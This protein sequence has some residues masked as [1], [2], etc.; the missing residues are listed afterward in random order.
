[1]LLNVLGGGQEPVFID[2]LKDG[3]TILTESIT[4][5]DGRGEHSWD[6]PAELFGTIELCAYRFGVH[7]LPVRKTRVIYIRQANELKIHTE[8]DRQE[9]RPGRTARI[10][11][12]LVDSQG[13]PTPGAISLSAVD[14]AV[15]SVLDQR[16][17]MEQTFFTLEQ[18]LLEPV[19]AIYPWSPST[20]FDVPVEER[21]L[22]EQALFAGTT[23]RTRSDRDVILRELLPFVDNSAEIFQVLERPD[24]EELIPLYYIPDEVLSILRNESGQHTLNVSTFPAKVRETESR[25]QSGIKF[26][27]GLWTSYALISGLLLF[28]YVCTILF[29]KNAVLGCLTLGGLLTVLS[30]LMLPAVQ[31]AREAARRSTAKNNLKQIELA[32][33]N[34]MDSE[35]RL[36]GVGDTA[37]SQASNVRVRQWFPET[38]LWRPELIT[39]DDGRV[40]LDVDLADSITTWRLA[41]SAVSASGQLGA[42]QSAIRVFQPFF[43]DLNL[44]VALTRGDEVSVPI[45]I[46]NYLDEPQHVEL[47]LSEGSWFESLDEVE[48]SIELKAGE[49][50]S[51]SYRL[52]VNKVGRHE[53]QV[54][55]V[56]GDVADAIRRRIEVVPDGR[57]IERVVNGTLGQLIEIDLVVPPE[58]IEGS[59]KTIV[60]LYPSSFSQLVEGLDAIFRRPSGCFEQTSSTT[61]PN[62]LAIDYLRKANKTVPAVEAK[63]R[64]YI[65]LGYQRLLSFEISGGGFDWFGHPPANRTLT[66]YG[67]MEFKDMARVYDVDP[68]LIGRTRDWLLNQR[69]ANGSWNPEDHRLH[70]DP[71]QRG[72]DLARLSTTA[73]IAW[74]VFGGESA[75]A[76]L[77]ATRD[78][79]LSH[80]PDSINDPYTLS[81]VSN[82]LLATGSS[83]RSA[84]PYLNRLES[85]KQSSADGKLVWWSR[86][87]SR[88]TMFYGAG[89]AENIETTALATL[90]I[91]N[92][93][94]NPSTIRKALAWVIEQKD[95]HGIWH[96]TQATVLALKALIAATGKPLG[97]GQQRQI[98]IR[99]D[100]KPFRQIVIPVGQAD[101]MQQIDL[102]DRIVAGNHRLTLRDVSGSATAFQV[103]FWFHSPLDSG[104]ER[105][106]PLSIQ[107][108]YDRDQLTVNETITATMVVTNNMTSS[109]PMVVL[110]LPIPAGFTVETIDL[111]KLVETKMIE[112][113]QQTPR[114]VIVYLRSLEPKKPMML[115]YR[116]RATMPV[117][118]TVPPAVAYEYYDADKKASSSATRLLVRA[119]Q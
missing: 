116:L 29:D 18:E 96:S 33:H 81:L 61:Y 57:R 48:R 114:S 87:A 20:L 13:Q 78:Y 85:I 93:G 89:Q 39:D 24:W 51:L 22:F 58:A 47:K 11:F 101:V 69:R 19:Y 30:F 36:P 32:V 99:L 8:L 17:G 75:I 31:Q 28:I 86:S 84:R 16:P 94:G 26:V 23:R 95:G 63:A 117:N 25:K 60:K 43:V 5:S 115:Q 15:Y 38:L 50:R 108:D 1:M 97:G 45:V 80:E 98:E 42:T 53:L 76:E 62:I 79:L 83:G 70:E 64:Q 90:A 110:D 44:P 9:Y 73:Y 55:A 27:K 91:L 72:G 2:L 92:G 103:A 41:A 10:S 40:S 100:E 107:L 119:A 67:L 59:I 112:K 37:E 104:M 4:M 118:I 35:G 88:R 82:A 113:Y 71:T 74:S 77:G 7:G 102:S 21:N 34:F 49:V 3:Q 52:R 106:E 111:E 105:T 6:L 56:S 54:T 14:E 109:A 68:N 65:H 46:Y 12:R 66:A